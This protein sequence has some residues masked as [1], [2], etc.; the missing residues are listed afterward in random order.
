M[1]DDSGIVKVPVLALK[2]IDFILAE[3]RGNFTKTLDADSSGYDIGFWNGI[4]SL[5]I[6]EAKNKLNKWIKPE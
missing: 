5:K 3:V 6:E 4:S 2:E 1:E